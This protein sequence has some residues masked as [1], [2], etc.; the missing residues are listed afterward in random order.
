MKKYQ[1]YKNIRKK[2]MIFG[3]PLSL[4]AMMMVSI[5]ASLLVMIFSFS[6]VMVIGVLCFN[7]TLYIS[8]LRSASTPRF[9]LNAVSY[10]E[11]ISNRKQSNLNY[12]KH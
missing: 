9:F 10:P 11:I 12:E 6:F 5:I 2:A 1:V 4:F 8:L 7:T 3:L